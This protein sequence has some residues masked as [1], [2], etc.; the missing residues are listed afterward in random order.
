MKIARE[1]ESVILREDPDTVGSIVLEPITAGGGVITPPEGYWE[2]VQ[3]ICNKYG[4]LLHIDEV[5]CG[6]GRT[7]EWFGYQHYDIKPDIVTMAKGVASGY[8]AIAC[9]V[10]T[11]EVFNQFKDSEDQ[12]GYFRDCLLYTSPSPRDRG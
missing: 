6:L 4:I 11:E 9:T 5:V 12:M 1:I 3:E 2:T 10:T 8:A 7:G